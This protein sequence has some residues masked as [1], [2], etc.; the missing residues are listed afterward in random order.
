MLCRGRSEPA[1]L[2]VGPSGP[3]KEPRGWEKMGDG[4]EN[5][6]RCLS[7][8]H[9]LASEYRVLWELWNKNSSASRFLGKCREHS[10][11]GMARLPLKGAFFGWLFIGQLEPNSLRTL[12]EWHCVCLRI[13][14]LRCAEPGVYTP[15]LS[16]Q[17]PGRAA[18][19][20]C[21]F[22]ATYGLL[23]VQKSCPDTR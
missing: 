7:V 5:D 11:S 4:S 6:C 19:R 18:P 23:R 10:D 12:W 3:V 14:R 9:V 8:Q 20:A 1:G 13:I 15:A 2:V 17:T 16:H 21:W 22:P